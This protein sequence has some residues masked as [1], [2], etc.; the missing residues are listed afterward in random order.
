MSFT[1][2][3]NDV[4]TTPARQSVWYA[5]DLAILAAGLADNGVVSGCGIT[6]QGSPDMTV[7]V[8]SGIIL[9]SGVPVTVTSG[10]ATIGAADGSNPRIDLVSASSAGVKTVTAGTAA[11]S[12]KPPDLPAGHI[13][14][15]YVDVP[16]SDTTISTGQIVDKRCLL[17]AT[18]PTI[19]LDFPLASDITN[20]AI[21]AGTAFDV[22]A[23]QN[24]T[25]AVAGSLI[26]IK[27]RGNCFANDNVNNQYVISVVVNSGGTPI[28]KYLG[29]AADPYTTTP[30]N[31]RA[32]PFGGG[33]SVFISGLSAATHTVKV[34]IT[35]ISN[36]HFYLRAS[37]N[38]P[39]E[40]ANVQ[41]IE[42][43]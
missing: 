35:A 40:F 16:T 13:A 10:N 14:L 38:T 17:R 1:I 6:A 18:T 15:A 32:N 8:A 5:T 20:Q 29:G 24:F 9:A 12:P 2:P 22:I 34:Q 37:T 7:A 23:N 21:S 25:K 3:D 11:A 28:T 30:V 27:V 42:H 19:L 31:A 41:V 26:E 43:P 33:G 39:Y 36:D 4:A